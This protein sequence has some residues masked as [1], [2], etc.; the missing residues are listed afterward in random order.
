[1]SSIEAEQSWKFVTRW[2]A[3]EGVYI[4]SLYILYIFLI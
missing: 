2:G 1:M 4:D 3:F